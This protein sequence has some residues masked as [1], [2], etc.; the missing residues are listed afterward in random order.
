MSSHDPR[1]Y[2]V[3]IV[4]ASL[5]GCTAAILLAREGARVA[6]IERHAQPDAFKRL[7]THYIQASAFP[8]IQR[9]G[10]APLIERAG[11]VRNGAE[12]HTPFGWVG[13]HV[14]PQDM[15]AAPHGYNIRRER[16][17]PMLRQLAVATP[18]VT[19]MSGVTVKALVE[20]GGVKGARIAGVH[21]RSTTSESVLT[22]RLV[23]AAD[24]RHS[25]VAALAGIASKQAPNLRHG[26]LAVMRHVDLQRGGTSQ[27]WMTG[28]E[29][30]YVFP[31][32]DG[33]SVVAWMAPRQVLADLD[34]DAALDALKARLATLPDA[35]GLQRA[36]LVDKPMIVKDFP[37][38]WR[39]PVARG[40]ALVGDAATSLDYL[41]GVGCGWALQSA[42]W[43]ADA[44]SS[45][46]RP[47]STDAQLDAGLQ[48][49]ATQHRRAI[50]PQRFFINDFAGRLDF[51]PVERLLYAAA[52]RDAD[53]AR[54]MARVG[55]RIDTPLAL[56][57]P[58][59]LAKAVWL[60]LARR[61]AG[62]DSRG[63]V[64]ASMAREAA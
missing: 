30:A 53:L 40:M 36:E 12:I 3:A 18:G 46:L 5:A 8:V 10:L 1:S 20:A 49:Y 27:M 17:D 14:S 37:C 57:R 51:N 21:V 15:Q 29:V 4:G 26:M 59:V 35:P 44:V 64:V 60:N 55:A 42:Q 38:M 31:N 50:A 24:G 25:E 2:D 13:H 32:E 63:P 39:P 33:L 11:G 56:M 41:Q 19:L 7:C 58:S 9:L 23:V 34:R 61:G 22:A 16:L 6:L 52:A 54:R 45:S 28:P 47:G 43:L 62:W 48:R